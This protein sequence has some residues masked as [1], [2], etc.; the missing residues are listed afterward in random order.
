MNKEYLYTDGKVTIID[1]HGEEREECY[2]DNIDEILIKENVIEHMNNQIDSLETKRKFYKKSKA[3]KLF[4]LVPLLGGCVT[5]LIGPLLVVATISGQSISSLILDASCIDYIL[6]LIGIIFPFGLFFGGLISTFEYLQYRK[7]L[8]ILNGITSELDYLY[9]NLTKEKEQLL[10]LKN[11][12]SNNAEIKNVVI[13]VHD[14]V[15]LEKVRTNLEQYYELGYNM[16]KYYRYY[17]QGKLTE[18]LPDN[19]DS[20]L[21]HKYIKQKRLVKKKK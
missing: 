3:N 8:K 21:A 16:S 17:L 12:K 5:S 9:E 14:A 20:S 10:T 4:V 6:S 15:E 2:A 1:E 19:I 7:D 11:S 18:N 13:K